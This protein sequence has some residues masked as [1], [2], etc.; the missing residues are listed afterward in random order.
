MTP[1][2]ITWLA[3]VL[4]LG[5]CALS[6]GG[7][8]APETPVPAEPEPAAYLST[9]ARLPS[10]TTL[11]RGASILTAAG[12]VIERGSV[13][14]RDGRIAA[15]GTSVTAPAD[16]EV[17][18]ATGKWVT[19]GLIDPHSHIGVGAA[20]GI[21]AIS[22]VNEAT[23]PNTAEVWAEHSIWP[24][25][26]QFA[27]ALAGGVTTAQLLPGSA[28]LFGGRTVTVK[29]VPVRTIDEMKFPG[30]PQGLKM[31]CGEN[32]KRVY[33]SRGPS[34]RMGNMAGF[35]QGF[36]RAQRYQRE[37][38]KW[39]EEG[40]DPAKQPARDL[41]LETL[42][43]ALDGRMPAQ[44][45]CYGAH[46]MAMMLDLAHEF[47]FRIGAFIHAVEAYKIRDL[48]KARDVCSLAWSDWWGFKLEAYDGINA[49]MALLEEDGACVALHSD[50]SQGIQRL[51][52]DAAKAMTAGRQA[53]IEISRAAAIRWIT[54][55]PAKTMGV[56]DSTG[57]LEPGKMADVVIWDRD[58]FSI[59]AH[60]EQV[61]IDG[62][63][64]YDRNDP[65][66]QPRSDFILG[67]L[68]KE[69]AR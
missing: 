14:I 30:A 6:R 59:Y 12:P 10:R 49:N 55:N 65:R 11:I 44:I 39:R 27:L 5:G 50:D 22:D 4:A 33:E 61:F 19:P 17:I 47:G 24:Q 62:A 36:V 56:A 40:A 38:R 1:C 52:Q 35:R 42:A 15:V 28:N 29:L 32:P 53:G 54:I 67:I 2:R 3:A 26:P 68:P 66:R 60:A 69:T 34:T 13:L 25:D 57:S 37:Q 58:P 48:L 8:A 63:L 41:Q 18:D 16:A 7:P 31:A 21:S 43:E 20:P 45:H 23:N 51:N 46:E 64:I 9:Y